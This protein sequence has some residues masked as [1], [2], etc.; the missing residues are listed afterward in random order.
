M[1]KARE[2][3]LSRCQ[4]GE[5]ANLL[6]LHW[7]IPK[8]ER[9]QELDLINWELEF[10]ML[11]HN[12]LKTQIWQLYLINY[13]SDYI[14][15]FLRLSSRLFLPKLINHIFLRGFSG[16]KNWLPASSSRFG[17]KFKYL[18]VVSLQKVNLEDEVVNG[19]NVTCPFL[20]ILCLDTCFGLK[21]LHLTG[22]LK[23]KTLILKHLL[24]LKRKN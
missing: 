24:T 11:M 12:V 22:F 23:L 8:T 2:I 19:F 15:D 7:V 21:N 17:D 18:S 4:G 14:K 3:V 20:A 5:S 9:W 1:R 6:K 16:L 13:N 10:E